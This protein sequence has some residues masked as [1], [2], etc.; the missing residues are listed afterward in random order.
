MP[1]FDAQKVIDV[2]NRIKHKYP[3]VDLLKPETIVAT[4]ASRRH[5]CIG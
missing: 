1:K 5:T 4:R 3:F 2:M